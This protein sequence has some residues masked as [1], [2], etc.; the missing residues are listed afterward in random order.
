VSILV[1]IQGTSVSRRVQLSTF[2]DTPSPETGTSRRPA[3]RHAHCI[4]QSDH[5]EL[6]YVKIE[7]KQLRIVGACCVL[8]FGAPA[9]AQDPGFH[10]PISGS[11]RSSIPTTSELFHA[12]HWYILELHE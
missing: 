9:F 5:R 4:L 3:R 6:R 11:T 1:D 10:A 2:V 8:L 7:M 12:P